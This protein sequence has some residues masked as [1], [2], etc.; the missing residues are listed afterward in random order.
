MGYN[1]TTSEIT[2]FNQTVAAS[3]SG[4]PTSLTAS[5]NAT[6]TV[7]FNNSFSSVTNY[8]VS[9]TSTTGPWTITINAY[10]FSGGIAGGQYTLVIQ[11]FCT[12]GGTTTWTFNGPSASGPPVLKSNFSTITTTGMTTG[13]T[14]Y[15]VLTMAYDGTTYFV[16][17]STFA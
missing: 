13:T 9:F 11:L 6:L 1:T 2:Y 12:G 17:G 5:A 10:A 15:I 4:L 7:N 8:T 14:R 16:S 3:P